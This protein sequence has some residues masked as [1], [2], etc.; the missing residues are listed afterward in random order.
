MLQAVQ[1]RKSLGFRA[2]WLSRIR[3]W[4]SRHVDVEKLPSVVTPVARRGEIAYL[5]GVGIREAH[6]GA[7]WIQNTTL[8]FYSMTEPIPSVP[9]MI[10]YE[11]GVVAECLKMQM[12]NFLWM[13]VSLAAGHAE[14]RR[15]IE[16]N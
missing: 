15:M 11:E 5:D 9:L 13:N 4:T 3:A 16:A 12:L 6:S 2:K 14:L 8:H 7:P 1:K 10:L